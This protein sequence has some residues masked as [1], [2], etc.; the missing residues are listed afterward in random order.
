MPQVIFVLFSFKSRMF[1]LN[2]HVGELPSPVAW[3]RLRVPLGPL[4]G[5]L[6][7]PLPLVAPDA[8]LFQDSTPCHL[9]SHY[10]SCLLPH[11]PLVC[12]PR[13]QARRP[14]IGEPFPHCP[15]LGR[16]CVEAWESCIT[17]I[18]L[19]TKGQFQLLPWSL[20]S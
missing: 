5:G 10:L 6:P 14:E 4:A 9:L 16:P 11:L 8:T 20:P 1:F 15:G 13:N 12:H 18:T 2:S 7:W 3:S 19:K 17:F